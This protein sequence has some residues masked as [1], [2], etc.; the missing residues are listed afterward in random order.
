[1]WGQSGP[2]LCPPGA[3]K[4]VGPPKTTESFSDANHE[5][6]EA[7]DQVLHILHLSVVGK[8]FCKWLINECGL[9]HSYHTRV[10]QNHQKR[11]QLPSMVAMW[12]LRVPKMERIKYPRDTVLGLDIW[13][14]QNKA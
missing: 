13:L 3:C 11:Q 9:A 8:V 12:P 14:L 1:M 4:L 10:K 2:V 6:S 7:G 5:P